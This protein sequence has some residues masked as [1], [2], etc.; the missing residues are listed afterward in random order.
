LAIRV[1]ENLRRQTRCNLDHCAAIVFASPSFVPMS[2]ARRLMEPHRAKQEQL[3]RAARRLTADLDITPRSVFA[4]NSFCSGY[5]KAMTIVLDKVRPTI[6]LTPSEFI[7]V[8]T[9]TRISRITDY[10]CGQ[11]GA[12]FGDLATATLISRCDSARYPVHLEL[13]DAQFQKKP[14]SRPFFDFALK[15]DVL[16]PTQDGG[17]I[18]D[19]KRVVFSLDGMG[20][21]DVAPRAMAEA[22]KRLAETNRLQ[23]QDVDFIVPHQAG[24]GIVRLAGMKLQAAGFDSELINGMT[25]QV[26]NVSSGS[27]PYTLRQIWERL[28]G[29]ILCP[30]AA[31]GAPGKS[32]VSQGCILLRATQR[33]RAMAA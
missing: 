14:T 26:G 6:E 3:A 30:V 20:I 33:Q 8:I 13:I 5:A 27:V 15:Q 16:A 2:V 12:L 32:E 11:T 17:R 1:V 31:V 9:S 28:E 29:N 23:P 24:T 10:A 25:A 7:L 21:A 22:A 18:F 19:S 4:T